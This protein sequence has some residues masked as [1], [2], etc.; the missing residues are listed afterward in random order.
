MGNQ[1]AANAESVSAATTQ[2]I[3][4]RVRDC[5]AIASEPAIVSA[6]TAS[7]G[8]YKRTA[9]AVTNEKI[10]GIEKGWNGPEAE[11]AAK[12]ILSSP[13]AKLLQARR[14]IDP[15]FL[16]IVAADERG[17]TVAASDKPANYVEANS[18]FWAD[19]YAGGHGA[20]SLRNAAYD[21]A[22]RSN[23]IGIA[24]PVKE[25]GSGR[26]LGAVSA[27]I[28][29]SP[30]LARLNAAHP[31]A[32]A[33]TIL[34]KDDGTILAGPNV[35]L[36]MN[37]KSEEFAAVRDTM[38]TFEGREAGYIV[39]DLRGGKR[40]LVGFADLKAQKEIPRPGWVVLVSQDLKTATGPL[41]AISLF[42]FLM[43]L[44]GL[45][46]LSLA[47]MYFFV[48]RTEEFTDIEALHEGSL[49]R[50]AHI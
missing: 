7:N 21:D 39:A 15:R 50:P 45:L 23:Y 35:D 30:M 41:R 38:G 33:R 17:V 10:E 29:I 9:D 24:V 6:M 14:G 19:V 49:P 40:S 1:Y 22:S 42:A 2:F 20:V 8:I 4:D 32:A 47:T 13:A 48:H 18:P 46:L 31:G 44:L 12:A 27:L 3:G 34:V 26:F 11:P 16:L 5:L 25:E 36:S 28:D 37:L 43:V